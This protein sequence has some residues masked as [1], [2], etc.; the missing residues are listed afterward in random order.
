MGPNLYLYEKALEVHHQDLRHEMEARRL[1]ARLP[2]Q[3]G[4]SRRAAGKLGVLLLKL[5]AWLKQMEQP[6]TA[7]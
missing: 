2:R 3:T 7:F 1:F 6:G 4:W 5:G